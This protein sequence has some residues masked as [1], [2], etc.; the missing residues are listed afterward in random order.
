[1]S[2]QEMK[3][4]PFAAK[5]AVNVPSPVYTTKTTAVKVAPKGTVISTAQP[6]LPPFIVPAPFNMFLPKPTPAKP[7]AALFP[8]I[9][10]QTPSMTSDLPPFVLPAPFNLLFPTPTPDKPGTQ[11]FPNTASPSL[12]TP[13]VDIPNPLDWLKD[14]KNILIIGGIVIAGIIALSFLR[15]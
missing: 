12:G 3:G 5:Y 9:Q 7:G 2:L 6:V 11:L 14:T 10:T 13:Q 4:T 1:M 8:N 15:K